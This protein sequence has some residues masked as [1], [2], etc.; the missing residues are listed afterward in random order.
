MFRTAPFKNNLLSE[1]EVKVNLAMQ[2]DEN[3]KKTNKF[4]NLDLEISK[5]NSLSL[6]WT[7]VHAIT[8]KSPLYGFS[9]EDMINANIEALVFIQAFDEIFSNTVIQ[10]FSYIASEIV[11]GAKFVIMYH[12]DKE[13]N[14]TVLEFKK[15][16][17]FEKVHLPDLIVNN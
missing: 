9:H 10:R 7:V 1:V 14:K 3:G 15:L 16:N 13:K 12:P 17:S 6:S 4:Y 11:W 2:V 8:D 5:I